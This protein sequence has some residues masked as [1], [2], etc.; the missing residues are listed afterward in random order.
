MAAR[1]IRREERGGCVPFVAKGSSANGSMRSEY[2]ASED[3]MTGG[4][5][6][7]AGE[8]ARRQ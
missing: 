4:N 3:L 2:G 5:R 1:G 6:V 8:W 7:Q